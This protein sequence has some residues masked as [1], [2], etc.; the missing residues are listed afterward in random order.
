MP[1]LGVAGIAGGVDEGLSVS[2]IPAMVI[3]SFPL[4]LTA[5]IALV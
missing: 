3:I 2:Q 1:F 5:N 4:V